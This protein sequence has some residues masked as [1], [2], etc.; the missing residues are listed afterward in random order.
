[1]AAGIKKVVDEGVSQAEHQ[2]RRRRLARAVGARALVIVPAA[3]QRLRNSDVEYAFR[4]NSDFLYLSGF[5]AADALLV[6]APGRAQGEYLLFC[7]ARDKTAEM[8]VGA[9]PG[10]AEARRAYAADAAYPLEKVDAMLPRLLAERDEVYAPIGENAAFDERLG[11][12]LRGA[13]R[14]TARRGAAPEALRCLRPLHE[15]RL[16]KGREELRLMRRAGEISARAHRSAMRACRPGLYEHHLEAAL[17]NEFVAAGARD[18]AYGSIVASGANAC[19]LH[20]TRNNAQIDDGDLLLI[21]AGCELGG[22]A[23]DITRTFPANGRFSA[24]QREVHDIVLAAQRAAIAKARP[25]RTI[26]QVHQAAV[27]TLVTGM[28]RLGWLKG[29]L[30]SALKAGDWRRFYPHRTG[31]WLGLDVHDVGDYEVGGRSRKLEAGMVMT[32]EP[33][34]Y[35]PPSSRDAAP[36]WRG[37][38]VRIEDDVLITKNGAEIIN[39]DAPRAADE[40]EAFMAAG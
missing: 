31:H 18:C 26:E 5:P 4:Q 30:S 7:R 3:S 9:Q 37:I 15:L 35:V 36:R 29:S 34:L 28:L 27:R 16:I 19:V 13:R 39:G 21:D 10:P 14:W 2:R 20:Y 40:I 11:D 33:G 23:S 32:V 24:E 38:G 22:Y 1:M 12:W 25:G 17:L 6:L 8:W